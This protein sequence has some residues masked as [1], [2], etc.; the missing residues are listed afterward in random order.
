MIELLI[1]PLQYPFMQ[2]AL[3]IALIISLVCGILSCFLILKSWS[4]M[5]DAISH[6]ILPGI[7]LAYVIGVPLILGAFITGLFCSVSIG[8]IKENTRIK[9]DTI[10]GIVFSGLF[11]IGLV[12]F[13]K[14]ESEQHLN[15]I[16][17]GN[18][19]GVSDSSLI[20]T[21]I[22]SILITF[23]ILIKRKDFLLYCFDENYARVSGLPVRFIYYLL[24]SLLTLCIVITLQAVG[25]ILVVALLVTPGII[26][27]TLSK[28]FFT[29]L[30]IAILS[31]ILSSFIG[32]IL[33]F[34]LDSATG[35]TIVLIHSLFFIFALIYSKIYKKLVLR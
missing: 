21:L 13:V 1:E 17:L 30:I 4:L 2:R 16:L 7:I 28:N 9:E 19:L 22:I 32:V 20:Q 34:H 23:I 14:V 8:Y 5:G 35:P 31:S 12:M 25:I 10:M 26:A 6:A 24:L 29:M 18:I 3:F 27:F 11:A 15:H 33:S